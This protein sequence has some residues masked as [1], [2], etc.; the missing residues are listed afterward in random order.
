MNTDKLYMQRCLLLAS[1]GLGSV[2]PNPM[3]GCV[4]VYQNKI[5]GEGFTSPYGQAHAEV[6]AIN[7]VKDK[8]LLKQSTLYVSLEP[9]ALNY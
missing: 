8:T 1:K 9:C 2:A 3:V 4:I 7:S 5:I 6:N